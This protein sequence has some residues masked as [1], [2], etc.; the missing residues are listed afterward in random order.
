MTPLWPLHEAVNFLSVGKQT[1]SDLNLL[2]FITRNEAKGG[3]IVV[4]V[5]VIVY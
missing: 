3:N 5:L 2:S 1:G 4:M